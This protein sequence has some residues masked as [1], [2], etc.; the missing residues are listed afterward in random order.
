MG[1]DKRSA[2]KKY[3]PR[4]DD[5]LAII[6]ERE[7]AAGNP[8]TEE[9]LARFNFGT[10]EV[11]TVEE[12]LRDR[13]GARKRGA[14]NRFV[15]TPDLV[16]ELLIPLAFQKAGLSTE[17]THTLK[18]KA[19]AAPPPQFLECCSIPGVTFDFDKSF[20]RPTVVEVLKPLQEAVDRHPDARIMIFGHTD[21]VGSESYNKA[22]SERRAKSVFAFI[23]NDAGTW[24]ALYNQESWGIRVVQQL[25]KDFGD[26]FDPGEPDGVQ[27][28][29]TT[30][31]IK[32]YQGARGL[33]V[34]GVAG[35]TTRKKMFTEYMTSKH[36]LK[37]TADQ[38][39][40]PK[41]MGCGEFNPQVETDEAN[42]ANRRVTLFLFDQSR[43]PVLPCKTTDL[44]PCKKQMQQPLPRF[45][46]SFHCS[47][48]DSIAHKCQ[49]EGPGP[50]PKKLTVKIVSPK[51]DRKQF[52]NLPEDAAHEEL[53]R[54][55]VIK[56][57][58]D[59]PTAG[60]TVHWAFEEHSTLKWK[61]V[62]KASFKASLLGTALQAGFGAPGT[63]NTTSTTDGA[64]N[65]QVDFQLSR[66]GGDDY[67]VRAGLS[68][69]EAQGKTAGDAAAKLT[70]FRRVWFQMT[71]DEGL[72]VPDVPNSRAAYDR[73]SA[74]LVTA[75]EKKFKKADAPPRTYY[76]EF[77]MIPPSA[78]DKEVAVIG[79]HNKVAFQG[80]LIVEADKPLKAHLIVCEHQWD[81]GPLTGQVV[82]Q[83][84]KS[85]SDEIA[86][87][88]AVFSPPLSGNLV[89][90]GK[91][92]TLDGSKSGPLADADILVQKGRTNRGRV[93]VQL[94][95]VAPTPT[96]AAK[97][98]VTL[99]L[100]A[101]SGPFLGESGSPHMLIVFQPSDPVDFQNTVAHEIMHG[102]NQTVRAGKQP[103]GM[104]DHPNEYTGH[105]GSGSH[106]NTVLD[107][108]GKQVKGTEATVSGQKVFTT[109]VCAMFHAKDK[110]CINRFC[111]TCEPYLRGEDWTKF[112]VG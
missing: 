37:L 99:K 75:T 84:D 58:V 11:D 52:I 47:F 34:D 5:T 6:A 10:A 111:D 7:T 92:E 46:E 68:L 108:A 14:D 85:P 100:R 107:A 24:E 13:L 67:I 16:G 110:T 69:A 78:S 8:V 17:Q 83:I 109:G 89:A 26:P 60:V 33:T 23:T 3:Q 48:F 19:Q 72:A 66:Y 98:K 15:M 104:I 9:E 76:P 51:T 32:E 63:K 90:T 38:F 71:R 64:G 106:C 27:G 97:I 20:I 54:K 95:A 88:A 1:F 22:L 21:K 102:L 49:C 57:Q 70:V 39:M 43:L 30:A 42:E 74:E 28:P 2:A 62:D 79:S 93:R 25:L 96:A 87:G 94:P 45:K 101:A 55:V 59:P 36:D 65:T 53:G 50:T 29:K 112:V 31:A 4:E 103:D 35:P 73:V 81:E 12:H 82:V 80:N 86:M 18:V 61:T 44:A 91:W 77:M 40:D 56:A 105:G 41:H